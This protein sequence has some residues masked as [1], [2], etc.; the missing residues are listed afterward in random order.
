MP[1]LRVELTVGDPAGCPVVETARTNETTAR[2]VNFTSS[3]S[4]TVEQFR[5]GKSASESELPAGVEPVFSYG[6]EGVYEF[7]RTWDDCIC[8]QVQALG[9][10][11]SDVRADEYGITV[12]LHLTDRADLI[13]V[14]STLQDVYEEVSIRSIVRANADPD[15]EVELVPVD[16]SRL[17]D[18]QTEVL[19]T[20]HAMGHFQYPREANATEVAEALGICPS[21]FAEHLAAAQAKLLGDLL[22]GADT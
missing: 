14:V 8:E 19:E 7:D 1:G 4:S 3:S 18:R 16:W 2:D 11:V 6:D 22:R 21:T 12:S 20:A 5:V 10:P 13:D 9:Y 17:T 15:D